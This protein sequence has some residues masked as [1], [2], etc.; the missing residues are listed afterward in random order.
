MVPRQAQDHETGS[1][2]H[3]SAMLSATIDKPFPKPTLTDK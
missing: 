1:S 2:G 3:L